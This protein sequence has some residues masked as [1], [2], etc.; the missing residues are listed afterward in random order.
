MRTALGSTPDEGGLAAVR[1]E[2]IAAFEMEVAFGRVV[3]LSRTSL[4][5]SRG[6]AVA[7]MGPSGS[8]K[9]TLLDCVQGLTRPTVGECVVLGQ[10]QSDASEGLRSDLRRR[11]MGLIQQDS[12][13]LPE[14]STVENVAFPLLFD[15][16]KRAE[17][18]GV[19]ENAL[20]EVGLSERADADVRTLSGGE[21]QRAAVARALTRSELSLI[22]ADEPTASLDAENAVLITEVILATARRRKASV[23]L[24]THDLEVASRCDRIVRLTREHEGV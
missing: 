10:D 12:N 7:I 21:A 17:A 1:D 24:A 2:V 20:A 19:A 16:S 15:G 8:G 9:S 3:A 4:V 5:V 11:R 22:V 13:L 6:E 18:L 23:L 14:F